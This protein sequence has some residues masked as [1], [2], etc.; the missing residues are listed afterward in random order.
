MLFLV[1]GHKL[2]SNLCSLGHLLVT[3]A[4]QAPSEPSLHSC[5]GPSM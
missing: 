2:D 5:T 4:E 1:V 3:I